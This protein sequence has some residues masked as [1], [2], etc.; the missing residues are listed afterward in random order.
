MTGFESFVRQQ[1]NALV[2]SDFVV[3]R[4]E[5]PAEL[6]RAAM[7]EG[8]VH[9]VSVADVVAAAVG[10]AMGTRK[11]ATVLLSGGA[12]S[13]FLVSVLQERLPGV[14]VS[15][16]AAR[17]KSN[18]G[19]INTARQLCAKHGIEIKV[20][21]P[22]EADLQ[23]LLDE[24]VDAFGRL[25]RDVAQP[26]HNL[27]VRQAY[28]ECA[29]ALVV[30]GQYADTLLFANPQ[31][32]Y[33]ALWRLFV[34]NTGLGKMLRTLGLDGSA[35]LSDGHVSRLDVLRS[36]AID[37]VD[38]LL[39][40]CRLERSEA[41]ERLIGELL[42]AFPLELAFQSVFYTCLL[43]YR[44]ADKYRM[45]PD[46]LSPFRDMALFYDAWRRPRAYNG[47]LKRK[48]PIWS[49]IDEHYP[50]L[51]DGVRRRSFEPR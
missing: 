2:P 51:I 42:A 32:T 35:S 45:Y 37:E 3:S 4:A 31:N 1:R 11:V 13:V 12:D 36:L 6:C 49:Y 8:G 50:D 26:L 21:T 39:W 7:S 9:P 25:P 41:V 28:R 18:A 10:R 38:L 24:F 17:T 27:I 43:E 48:K 29:D 33:V 30:D 22:A 19:E 40:L 34:R 20:V 16:I 23:Q 46:V 15:A 14:R 47:L 44:E 5:A